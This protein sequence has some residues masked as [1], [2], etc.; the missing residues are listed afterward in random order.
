M[1]NKSLLIIGN[2]PTISVVKETIQKEFPNL[3]IDLTDNHSGNIFP[4]IHFTM[5]VFTYQELMARL[6]RPNELA[7]KYIDLTLCINPNADEQTP[8]TKAQNGTLYITENINSGLPKTVQ[9]L[10]KLVNPK[11]NNLV[12]HTKVN[13][14]KAKKT[15]IKWSHYS[16]D[17]ATAEKKIVDVVTRE[18]SSFLQKVRDSNTRSVDFELNTTQYL[19][20]TEIVEFLT[21]LEYTTTV[22]GSKLTIQ[23]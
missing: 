9:E 8:T 11:T 5:L 12:V 23:W 4:E 2:L 20:L 14:T 18:I 21:E 15:N 7:D 13:T 10:N 19:Y 16:S 22:D 3:V 17:M 1:S 6:V